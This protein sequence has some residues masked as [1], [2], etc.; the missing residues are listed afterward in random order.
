VTDTISIIL[1]IIGGTVLAIIIII[2]IFIVVSYL[3]GRSIAG[4]KKLTPLSMIGDKLEAIMDWA[5]NK[6]TGW[7]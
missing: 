7:S 1:P 4:K 5:Y 6:G 2:T 3:D